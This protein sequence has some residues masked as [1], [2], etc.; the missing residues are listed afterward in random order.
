MGT[1]SES[2]GKFADGAE[3]NTAHFVVQVIIEVQGSFHFNT[4]INPVVLECI[5]EV[6]ICDIVDCIG[7]TNL[8]WGFCF[9]LANADINWDAHEK[10]IVC[11]FTSLYITW[12]LYSRMKVKAEV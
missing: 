4:W 2:G 12:C 8:P 9:I 1:N 7:N 5:Y 10:R 11:F 3:E 6:G